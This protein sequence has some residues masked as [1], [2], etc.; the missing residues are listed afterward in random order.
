MSREAP[1]EGA[2]QGQPLDAL[3]WTPPEGMGTAAMKAALFHR[4]N[5]AANFDTGRNSRGG[6][7]AAVER[8]V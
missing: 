6:S 3:Y 2:L 8:A 5:C 7:V 4:A 1:T